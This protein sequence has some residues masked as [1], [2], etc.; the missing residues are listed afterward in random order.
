MAGAN[1][2]K[3]DLPRAALAGLTLLGLAV[4]SIG[5]ILAIPSWRQGVLTAVGALL[6]AAD[7][8]QPADVIV[9]ATD[10]DGAGV[11]EAADLVQ[12]GLAVRVALF[13]DPPDAIDQEFVRRGV[14]YFNEA[15]VSTQQL[16]ALGVTAVEEIP[17]GVTG[18]EDEGRKLP[19][20]CRQKGYK[21]VIFISTRDHS[22]RTRR[23]LERAT[24]GEELRVIVVPSRY[25]DFDPNDWWRSRT[26][27][28]TEI[29][30]SEKLL[31]DVLRHPLS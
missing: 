15:A 26:G 27:V 7:P 20:W 16:R 3:R 10:A 5:V 29:V 6:V 8:V 9:I 13:E 21:S 14:P 28:R 25:S 31:L 19:D 12:A 17:R 1:L 22:R 11:L 18:T 24:R 30:E 4:V 23:V 2:T